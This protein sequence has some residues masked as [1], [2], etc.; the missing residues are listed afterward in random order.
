[1]SDSKDDPIM[2]SG[3]T[4]L[5]PIICLKLAYYLFDFSKLFQF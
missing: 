3:G 1:V 2:N 4:G 5:N